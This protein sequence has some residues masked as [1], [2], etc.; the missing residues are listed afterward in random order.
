M[1]KSAFSKRGAYFNRVDEVNPPL[2][3]DWSVE[4]KQPGGEI[5]TGFT[6]PSARARELP[7]PSHGRYS[8]TTLH[9]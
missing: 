5:K 1:I 7:P 8:N 3:I 6:Q 2:E 9:L 4:T